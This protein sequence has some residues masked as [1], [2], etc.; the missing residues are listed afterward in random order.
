MAGAYYWNNESCYCLKSGLD[1]FEVPP[2]DA[3]TSLNYYSKISATNSINNEGPIEFKLQ[4]AEK[5]FSNLSESFLY[6]KFKI[7][8]E[9]GDA[10]AQAAGGAPIPATS[11]VYPINYCAATMFKTVEVYINNKKVSENSLYPYR[12]YLEYLLTY[13]EATKEEQGALALFHQDHGNFNETAAITPVNNKGAHARFT[14]TQYGKACEAL[15]PIHC[16]IFNQH[17]LFPG[18]LPIM[19]KFIRGDPKFTLMSNGPAATIYQISI[20]NA[21]LRVKKEVVTDRYL[22]SLKKMRLNEYM[23]YPISKVEMR[24]TNHSHNLSELHFPRLVS[25]APLPKRLI[26]GLVRA[27][28]FD[29][30]LKHNPFYFQNF[31][32]TSVKVTKGKDDL[33]FQELKLDY[34]NDQYK[35]AYQGLVFATGRLFKNT[36]M[37]ITPFQYK[38]GN[39]LYVFDLAKSGSDAPTFE[40]GETGTIDV[41]FQLAAAHAFSIVTVAYLEYDDILTVAPNNAPLYRSVVSRGNPAPAPAA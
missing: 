2:V 14:A 25:N 36:S 40:L 7:L 13:D 31:G 23:K 10:P 38:N 1:L 16:D 24:Y 15:V 34:E 27:E 20:Q 29:G 18:D 5:S 19:I 37:G 41:T 30:H 21:E 26:L 28:G 4:E 35:I 8:L 22:E 32:V 6:L 11:L 9:N 12:S 17:K 3:G 39:C 33:P